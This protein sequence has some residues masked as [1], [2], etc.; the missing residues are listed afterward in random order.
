MNPILWCSGIS[1]RNRP[2]WAGVYTMQTQ[3]GFPVDMSFEMLREKG[4]DVDWREAYL[5][6]MERH[7]NEYETLVSQAKQLDPELASE[8]ER[9]FQIGCQVFNWDLAAFRR[10]KENTRG[11]FV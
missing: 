11:Q 6:A 3:E 5:S 9:G 1:T 2:Q 10:Y 4:Y 7:P 8:S